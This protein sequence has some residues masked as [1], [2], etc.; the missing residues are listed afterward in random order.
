[1]S[2]AGLTR[3]SIFLRKNGFAK[4][5][6]CRVKPGNDGPQMEA[7]PKIF[8]TSSVAVTGTWSEGREEPRQCLSTRMPLTRS[9]SVGATQM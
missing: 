6:D 9:A 5:M 1:M 4:K 2:P 3:G 8:Y 7:R